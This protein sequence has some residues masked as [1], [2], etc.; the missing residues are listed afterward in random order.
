MKNPQQAGGAYFL[1]VAGKKT[2]TRSVWH[3]EEE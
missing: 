1:P 2:L 3:K